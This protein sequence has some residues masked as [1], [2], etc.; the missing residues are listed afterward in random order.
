MG[1]LKFEISDLKFETMPEPFQFLFGQAVPRCRH[2]VDKRFVGYSALQFMIAGAVDLRIDSRVFAL[3]GAWFF[4]SYPGPH[5]AFNA[6]R[7]GQTWNHRYITFKG[8]LLNRWLEQGLF[9]I[10]PQQVKKPNSWGKRFDELL[11]LI[12]VQDRYSHHR[13]RLLLEMILLDLAEERLAAHAPRWLE[14]T[15][16]LTRDM[17]PAEVGVDDI[18][19]RTGV[20]SRTLRRRFRG[21][22]GLSPKQFLIA[23]RINR[24]RQLLSETDLP[25]KSIADSL[26]YRDVFYFTRQFT[27]HAGLSPAAYRSEHH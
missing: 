11:R 14:D 7:P 12:K 13:A 18:V 9:P 1:E 4:S 15:A 17:H 5:I 20:S 24:A 10:Q 26:G 21:V 23:D 8:D 3:R 27:R 6:A 25:I 16:I 2:V 22:T 19:A